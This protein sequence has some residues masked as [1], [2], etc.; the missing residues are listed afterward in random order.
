MSQCVEM[1][2]RC[3]ICYKLQRCDYTLRLQNGKWIFTARSGYKLVCLV[4]ICPNRRKVCNKC[5]FDNSKFAKLETFKNDDSNCIE[6]QIIGNEDEENQMNGKEK[7]NPMNGLEIVQS[8]DHSCDD[9]VQINSQ[10]ISLTEEMVE[11]NLSENFVSDEFVP[12]QILEFSEIDN[13]IVKMMDCSTNDIPELFKKISCQM[14]EE[15]L[16]P[17]GIVN[18]WLL[19]AYLC[20]QNCKKCNGR[21]SFM[22]CNDVAQAFSLSFICQQCGVP[23]KFNSSPFISGTSNMVIPKQIAYAEAAVASRFS[24]SSMMWDLAGIN[25]LGSNKWEENVKEFWKIAKIVTENDMKIHQN[26]QRSTYGDKF[27]VALDFRWSKRREAQLGTAIATCLFTG[28]VLFRF[29]VDRTKNGNFAGS[30]KEMEGNGIKNICSTI[31]EMNCEIAVFTHDNDGST[32][33]IVYDFWPMS[34]EMLDINHGSRNIVSRLKD[35][36]KKGFSVSGFE[37]KIAK[38]WSNMTRTLAAGVL[39]PTDLKNMKEKNLTILDLYV[40][41]IRN[42]PLHYA[43]NC[44]CYCIHDSSWK[45]SYKPIQDPEVL[46]AISEIMEN[47]VSLAIRY[48]HKFS[49]NSCEATNQCIA[50]VLPKNIHEPKAYNGKVDIAIGSKNIGP[51][52]HLDCLFRLGCLSSQKTVN[53]ISKKQQFRKKKLEMQKN[54]EIKRKRLEKKK[55]KQK[56]AE[57]RKKEKQKQQT[58]TYKG[59]CGCKTGCTTAR[60]RCFSDGKGCTGNCKCQ[61]CKNSLGRNFMEKRTQNTPTKKRKSKHKKEKTRKK[62]KKI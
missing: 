16:Q 54:Q 32:R 50:Q 4:K 55:Q 59:T 18:K 33:K 10:N 34:S 5:R 13:I 49:S 20:Q 22:G 45:P 48:L 9:T 62:R 17:N 2:T 19:A 6:A 56:K 39:H 8:L 29:N 51:V 37:L 27:Y 46:E 38:S 47:F 26:W 40:E 3:G 14:D 43:G 31:K 35:L 30:A 42:I 53:I 57:D 1:S 21:I 61:T 7:N 24:Q 28:K 23:F 12:V 52:Y 25:H 58:H 36:K 44:T 15:K 11:I 41:K 60:C